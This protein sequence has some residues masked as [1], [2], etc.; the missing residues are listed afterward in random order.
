MPSDTIPCFKLS[1]IQSKTKLSLF[2]EAPAKGRF[3]DNP[4]FNYRSLGLGGLKYRLFRCFFSVC[5]LDLKRR[6]S[7]IE[8]Q[9]KKKAEL[10]REN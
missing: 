8:G 10:E 6:I 2:L 5:H 4:Y 3:A 7:F 9:K 1:D